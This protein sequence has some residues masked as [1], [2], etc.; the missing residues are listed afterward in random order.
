MS[1]LSPLCLS[2]LF[3]VRPLCNRSSFLSQP[4]EREAAAEKVRASGSTRF[5]ARCC[6]GHTVRP[7][8]CARARIVRLDCIRARM[9]FRSWPQLAL[10]RLDRARR[11][12]TLAGALHGAAQLQQEAER[13]SRARTSSQAGSVVA[14]RPSSPGLILSSSRR[15]STARAAAAYSAASFQD[16]CA[17]RAPSSELD[18]AQRL[19]CSRGASS[20]CSPASSI[21]SSRASFA[22]GFGSSRSR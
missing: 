15:L 4:S 6:A 16:R 22:R 19:L 9:E 1:C 14:G 12:R 10:P 7:H 18:R 2:V 11:S 3:S 21:A 8:G 20:A 5:A 13:S 17:A